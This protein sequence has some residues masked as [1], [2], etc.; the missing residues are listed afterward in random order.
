MEKLI[1]SQKLSDSYSKTTKNADGSVNHDAV[2]LP[3]MKVV[4]KMRKREPG[5]EPQSG[6]RVPFVLIKTD[7]KNAKQF[8]ISEDPKWVVQNKLPLDYEYY[9]SNKFMNPV[10]DLLEP[11]VANPKE[12]IFGDLLA[13]KKKSR[14]KQTNLLDLFKSFEDKQKTP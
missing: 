7:I 11:L 12:E 10:C 8:E 1:L 5:S 14:G 6:D 3:H 2:N 13:P 4:Q 9:F